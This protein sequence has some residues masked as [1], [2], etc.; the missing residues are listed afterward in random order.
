[1]KSK[2]Q[3]YKSELFS[4]QNVGKAVYED[5]QLLGISSISQ[6]A[7]ADPDELYERLGSLTGTTP[8]PCMWDVLASIVHEARTGVKTPWFQWT[9][10]RKQRQTQIKKT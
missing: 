1:M 6:L 2:Q 10:V 9:A 5:L 4:L 7:Q 3:L 8:N